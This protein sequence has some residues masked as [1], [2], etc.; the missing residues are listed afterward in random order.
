MKNLASEFIKLF[1]KKAEFDKSL[2]IH[3]NGVSNDYPDFVE[4]ILAESVTASTCVEMMTSYLTGKGFGIE[5]NKIIVHKEKGTTLLELTKC[6]SESISEHKGVF[7]HVNY[8]G[9]CEHKD[10]DVLPFSHC[11]VG[12][13]DD[14]NYNGKI[15]VCTDWNDSKLA[16]KARVCDVYNPDKEVVKSQI[17]KAGTISKYNGQILF[18]KFGKYTYPLAPIHPAL[19]DAESENQVSIYK[20]TSLKKGFFGK[21]LIVTK[22]MVD[23][24][25]EENQNEEFQ[26]QVGQRTNFRNTIKQFIGVENSEGAMHIEMQFDSDKIE[27]EFY[28]KVIETNIDDKLFAHTETSVSENICV[29]YG[30]HPNLVRPKDGSMFGNSG[31]VYKQMKLDFQD[32]T[33]DY[34]SSI[35]EVISKLMK[36]FH[37]PKENLKIIPLIA[38]E[39]NTEDVN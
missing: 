11:R 14:N 4:S 15:L 21:M 25:L 13:K 8:N 35:N 2:N 27:D 3:K 7:I 32:K 24:D 12:K 17:E 37:E 29:A 30:I 38:T 9:E 5:E 19:K 26:K 34:R 10:F 22:P 36:N 39:N 28:I 1:T 18:V 23:N 20:H 6:I 31:E 16:K 33:E